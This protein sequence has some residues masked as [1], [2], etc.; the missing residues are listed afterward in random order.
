[1]VLLT[2]SGSELR[3][4]EVVA[5]VVARRRTEESA[6]AVLGLSA[7]QTR[8]LV[9]AYRDG[10]GGALIHKA[11]GKNSNNQLIAGVREYAVELVK[12]RYAD[13]G[14]TLAAEVLFEKDGVKVSRETLRKWMIEDGLWLS[15]RQRRSFHQPRLRR[16]SYGELIQIDGS[17]HRWFERRGSACSLLVFIDDATGRL[18]QLRFVPSESTTS[19]FDCLRGYLDAHGCP[20]AFYSDKHSVFRINREAQGGA[21]M[22]QFGRALAE[23]NIEIICANSSQAKGRVERVN[24]TLQD[25][26]VKELRLANVCDMAAGN[27]FLAEFLV[28]FNEKFA[29][30]AARPEDLHRP[31]PVQADRLRDILCH[32]EQRHVGQQLTLAYD[33]KQLILDR[34]VVS[35]ELGGQYVDL[36]DFSDGQL[37]VRWK[38][39][40]LPYRVFDKD[41]RVSHAAVVE[42]KRLGHALRI[43]KAE[44]DVNFIPKIKTNSE[45]IGYRKR[46]RKTEAVEMT[47]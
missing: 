28:R 3:R 34:S 25:R 40:V 18:M 45:K 5:E 19:Y 22:T 11:R 31:V 36:Y 9:R 33:R 24:R 10:G 15:R 16:E 1:M 8:R 20:V 23:L 41:Q 32:R 35:E 29:V 37:E 42:N 46:E 7:R 14:P 2:M 4:V 12:T 17:D 6:A 13:F 43:I 21:G 38:G 26:L 44:Q 30:R 27:V 47:A 39:Q